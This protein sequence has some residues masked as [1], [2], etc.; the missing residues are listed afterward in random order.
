MTT[1]TFDQWCIIELFGHSRISGRVT[2]QSIGGSSFVRVDVPDTSHNKGFTKFYGPGA[3]YAITP[4]DEHTA[5]LAA[6][7]FSTPP[8]INKWDI[9]HLDLPRL[10]EGIGTEENEVSDEDE[11]SF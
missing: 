7:V 8:P 2:E 6:E 5:R 4:T 9:S 11:F 10:T 1:E 3:I